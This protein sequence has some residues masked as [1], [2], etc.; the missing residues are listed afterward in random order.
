MVQNSS[1]GMLPTKLLDRA[2]I[3]KAPAV[4]ITSH[5]DES[6]IY[7]TIYCRKLRPDIQIITRAFLHRSVNLCIEQ[8]RTS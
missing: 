1:T 2:G 5:N 7:L 8:E 3:N 6:N 4:V